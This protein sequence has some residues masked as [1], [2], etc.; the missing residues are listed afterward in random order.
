M[1]VSVEVG[2]TKCFT[3]QF[4]DPSADQPV[5]EPLRF[6]MSGDY[7][8]DLANVIESIT[9]AADGKQID[10]I[11]IATPGSLANDGTLKSAGNMR[12]WKGQPILLDLKWKF[13]VPV[14]WLNDAQAGAY[15]EAAHGDHGGEN[16]HFLIWGTGIGGSVVIFV[17]GRFYI[18]DSETGHQKLDW[19]P[20][21]PV[22]PG[23]GKRGCLEA[24]A[25]GAGIEQRTGTPA[26]EI[27]DT[28]WKDV[29][30]YMTRGLYN[31]IRISPTDRMVIGG[32][33]ALKQSRHFP[34]LESGLNEL[35][36]GYRTVRLEVA[37]HGEIAGLIGA[38]ASLQYK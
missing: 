18:I 19:S 2:G 25:S 38:V 35:L 10:D 9:K 15:A 16:F 29:C 36:D 33:V 21:A 28:Q 4:T 30:V 8:T 7:Q 34:E 31:T 12:D 14:T 13:D 3:A 23:C 11:V 32:G 24:Y 20:D 17:D 37:K 27:D 6:E 26:G 5:A 1:I 22:C